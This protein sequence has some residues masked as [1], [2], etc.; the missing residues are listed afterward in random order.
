MEK[1]KDL[2][3]QFYN[4]VASGYHDKRYTSKNS[5]LSYG[6]L[7]RKNVVMKLVDSISTDG[8]KLLDVGCGGGSYAS[9]FLQKGYEVYGIDIS[10]EMIEQ[11]RKLLSEEGLIQHAH[12]SQGDIENLSFSDNFFDVVCSAGVLEYLETD[13]KAVKEIFRVLKPDGIAIITLNNKRGYGN[14]VRSILLTPIKK[15]IAPYFKDRVACSDF[16]TRRHVP[17][18]F[19]DYMTCCGFSFVAGRFCGFSLIPFGVRVP[20]L[21]FYISALL[22]KL[23][24]YIGLD[25]IFGA[26]AGVF[27]KGREN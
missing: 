17:K 15:I 6:M 25:V 11:A 9:E 4:N 19:I 10:S 22:E 27:K 23:M 18:K 8:K 26:Y 1:H 3:K 16:R 2:I 21:Y 20:K 13:D 5:T 14:F 24:R 12:F 7:Q